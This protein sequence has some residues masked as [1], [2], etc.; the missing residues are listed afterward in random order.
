MED[1]YCFWPKPQKGVPIFING[2]LTESYN[3]DNPMPPMDY[4][5]MRNRLG[6]KADFPQE[7]WLVVKEKLLLSDYYPV[8][9]GIIVSESFLN[10]IKNNTF[11]D[12][13]QT[14]K[15]NTISAKGKEITPK[16]YY[17]LRFNEEESLIDYEKSEFL[18][19]DDA[20]FEHVLKVGSGIKEFKEI[21]LNNTLAETNFFILRDRMFNK[22][23]FSNK[24]FKKEIEE[25]NLYGF[26]IIH[27]KTLPYA[28]N[29]KY[30]AYI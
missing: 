30:K 5:W 12:F 22:Y 20:N 29:E 1:I 19:E 24:V 9:K 4:D 13:Y 3:K 7:L 11:K 8:F 17:Y 15:L 26:D 18:L 14:I 27:Y 23:L 21:Y 6:K 10:I 28:Y 2:V 16:K 25:A